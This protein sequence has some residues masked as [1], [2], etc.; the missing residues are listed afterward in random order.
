MVKSDE[1][2]KLLYLLKPAINVIPEIET[3]TS[4]VAF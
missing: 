4:A 1:G 3:P 2:T